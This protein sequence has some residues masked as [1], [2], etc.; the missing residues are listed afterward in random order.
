M[1]LHEFSWWKKTKKTVHIWLYL[2]YLIVLHARYIT[3]NAHHL[4]EWVMRHFFV[5]PPPP[6]W[7]M[8]RSFDR[9]A[10]GGTFKVHPQVMS[11]KKAVVIYRYLN[12]ILC[13]E[14]SQRTDLWGQY[15]KD[16]NWENEHFQEVCK[17]KVFVSSDATD[18]SWTAVFFPSS[19]SVQHCPY[20]N[21]N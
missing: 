8:L 16:Y 6:D 13:T 18:V 2:Y 15:R 11:T 17:I 10:W 5:W 20:N 7:L 1:S 14:E 4:D 19:V 9:P 12:T 3:R 21:L